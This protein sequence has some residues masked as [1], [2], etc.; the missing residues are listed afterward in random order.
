MW[1]TTRHSP[2]S[3]L[4][5]HEYVPILVRLL[6]WLIYFFIDVPEPPLPS[7]RI[8]FR[9]GILLHYLM[10]ICCA[11]LSKNW[12]LSTIVKA[13][14]IAKVLNGYE[15][16]IYNIIVKITLLEWLDKYIRFPHDNFNPSWDDFIQ[17][18]TS[19]CENNFIK[20]LFRKFVRKN[21]FMDFLP[22]SVS[23]IF[24]YEYPLE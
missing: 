8:R 7:L 13:I 22:T 10:Q 9:R 4:H 6:F 15:M 1:K 11:V 12:F 5:I 20:L 14:S 2:P 24:F 19:L 3:N 23:L 21:L 18:N 16:L 17:D